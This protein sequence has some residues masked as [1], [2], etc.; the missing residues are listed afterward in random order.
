[1]RRC[2]KQVL[3]KEKE[4]IKI[5]S[6]TDVALKESILHCRYFR[7]PCSNGSFEQ[8]IPMMGD[9]GTT[10]T[11]HICLGAHRGDGLC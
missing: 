1:M 4:S 7:R 2:L 10:A 9:G 11:R 8:Q 3:S 5:A 6:R